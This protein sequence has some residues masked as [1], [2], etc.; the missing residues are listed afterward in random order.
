MLTGPA[1]QRQPTDVG[2]LPVEYQQV[3]GFTAKL[4]QQVLS[5][6]ET[7]QAPGIF[8]GFRHLSQCL[9]HPA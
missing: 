9:F 3:E 7:M 5:S 1:Q 6:L 4:T 8:P 2:Q